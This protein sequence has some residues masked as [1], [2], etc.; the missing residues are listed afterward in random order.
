MAS[1]DEGQ[2]FRATT[3]VLTQRGWERELRWEETEKMR[4]A[5][6]SVLRAK[7]IQAMANDH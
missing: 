5:T 3:A 2:N 7:V 1:E 4:A 6:N